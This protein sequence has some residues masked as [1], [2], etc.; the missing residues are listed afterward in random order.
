MTKNQR[1]FITKNRWRGAC[2]RLPPRVSVCAHRFGPS[3][4][5]WFVG[6]RA[7]ISADLAGMCVEVRN[8]LLPC[9]V[10]VAPSATLSYGHGQRRGK[11]PEGKNRRKRKGQSGSRLMLMGNPI[12]VGRSRAKFFGGACGIIHSSSGGS[13]GRRRLSIECANAFAGVE[14]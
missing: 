8:A 14:M 6:T 3:T 2:R 1:I 5:R 7:I 11:E 10:Q 4:S 13:T 9:R 12:S